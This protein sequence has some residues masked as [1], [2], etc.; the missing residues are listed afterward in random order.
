MRLANR[1]HP[2][3]RRNG[4]RFALSRLGLQLRKNCQTARCTVCTLANP[5]EIPYLMREPSISMNRRAFVRLVVFVAMLALA[6]LALWAQSQAGAIK[7]VRLSGTVSKIAAGNATPIA[8]TEG[9]AV[10]ETDIIATGADSGVVL[11]F[12]NGASVK[13]GA[14]SRLAIEEFKMDPLATDIAVADLQSEP[15][16]S[17]TRLNLAYG[18][19]VGNVKKLNKAAGSSFDIKTPV[20][21]AGIRGTT[22]R[23]VM[24]IAPSGQVTF[25]LSTAEGNVS[26]TGTLQVAAGEVS[27]VDGQEVTATATVNPVTN[28]VTS[29]QIS[30]PQAISPEAAQAIAT[31]V[32]EAIQQAQQSTT[33]TEAEQQQAAQQTK[34]TPATDTKEQQESENKTDEQTT[35]KTSVDVTTRSGSG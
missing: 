5:P 18:E 14:N 31:A 8:L 11:V 34:T 24:Q 7:A 15:N 17:K 3:R 12:A 1:A 19:I 6:P 13:V 28:E 35:P 21:A 20:G 32:T 30:T 2:S 9:Q 25:T 29:V 16:V 33:F 26:F 27:V 23:I 10:I 22:F 4:P